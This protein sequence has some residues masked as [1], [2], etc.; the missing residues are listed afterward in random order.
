MFT[1]LHND[2]DTGK[3]YAHYRY[4]ICNDTWHN[5][6]TCPN[7]QRMYNKIL[8]HVVIYYHIF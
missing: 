4:G 3:G 6:K 5:K 2:M 8:G 1:R 7:R